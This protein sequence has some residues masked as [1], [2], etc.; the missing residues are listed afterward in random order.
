LNSPSTGLT[1]NP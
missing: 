1:P